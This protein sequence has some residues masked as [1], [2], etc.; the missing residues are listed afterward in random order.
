MMM[1]P[2]VS[3]CLIL[4]RTHILPISG[5]SRPWRSRQHLPKTYY[6]SRSPGTLLEKALKIVSV[7]KLI[8]PWAAHL[9]VDT[10]IFIPHRP[11]VK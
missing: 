11:F 2:I 1:V 9:A 3:W 4:V 10:K 7:I 8:I 5:S 6:T